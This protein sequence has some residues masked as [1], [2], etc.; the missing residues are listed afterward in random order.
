MRDL[1]DDQTAS[2]GYR[3]P[4]NPGLDRYDPC[5]IDPPT[6]LQMFAR[7]GVLAMIALAVGVAAELFVRLPGH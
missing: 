4:P 6:P 1:F 2:G 5:E 3:N 7:F